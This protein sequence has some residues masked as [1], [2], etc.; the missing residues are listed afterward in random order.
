M[1]KAAEFRSGQSIMDIGMGDGRI[2][3]K[4]V[5]LGAKRA[6]GWELRESVFQLAQAHLQAA[7]TPEQLSRTEIRLGD[8][9][10]CDPCGIDLV[11]LF[12]LPSGLLEV[13]NL[14]LHKRQSTNSPASFPRT[15]VSAGWPLPNSHW[16]IQR[17]EITS[18][19]TRIFVHA[20]KE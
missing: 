5:Q 10:D 17:E 4:A 9:K 12:L 8:A 6:V 3:I 11:T 14:L 7:L 20:F 13:S 1:F 18:G 2:L 15:F 16:R 19:G